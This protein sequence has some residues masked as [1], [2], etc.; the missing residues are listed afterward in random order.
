MQRIKK[1]SIILIVFLAAVTACWAIEGIYHYNISGDKVQPGQIHT[2]QSNWVQID[3]TS[4]TGDEPN[5]LAVGE[6]TYATVAAAAEGGDDE[7]SIYGDA[8]TEID[9]IDGWNAVRFRCIGITNNQSVTYQIYVGAME[10]GDT[11]CN[12]AKVGQLAFTVG[13]QVSSTSTYELADAVTITTAD[14]PKSWSSANP[15]SDQVA[16]ASI[17]LMGANLIV[18]V[19]TVAGCDCQLLAKGY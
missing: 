7:I 12:L 2:T 15:G 5:D 18:A 9:E 8:A 6:R 11:D 16:E 1:L 14:W 4:S 10:P 17:D 13:Q 3:S 19:P